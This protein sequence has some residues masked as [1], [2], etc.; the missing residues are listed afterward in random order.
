MLTAI[1]TRGG[2]ATGHRLVWL[3]VLE[4]NT[5]AFELYR[6]LGFEPTFRWTRWLA[7]A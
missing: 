2:L 3:S 1:A 4:E 6:S 5:A 7:P